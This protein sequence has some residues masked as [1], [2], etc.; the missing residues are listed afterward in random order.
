[1]E[2]HTPVTF[3]NRQGSRLFGVLDLPAQ[4]S[5]GQTSDL[6][7]IL[8]SPG[9]KMR[10]GPERLYR[11][12]TDLF[13]GMGVPSLRFD[14]W[15]LGDSE[16]TLK[17][18]FLKDVYNHIEVGR[19]VDDA[20]DAMDWMQRECGT[21]R[22]ILSGL[23]G[24][25]I[26]G[27][28]AGSRDRRVAGLLALGITPT[29]ASRAAD[30]SLYMTAGELAQMRRS[31]VSKLASPTAWLRLLTLQ[32]DYKVIWRSVIHPFKTARAGQ[33]EASPPPET[34]NASPL[35]PPAFFNMLES[36]RPMLLI[37]GGSDRLHWEFEEKFVARHGEK[38]AALPQVY[39]VHVIPRANHV[40]SFQEWQQEMVD[41]SRRWL[42]ANFARDVK[43][44][45][46]ST[47]EPAHAR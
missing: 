36:R 2:H 8:L 47:P 39:D 13:V 44:S 40:L 31:Y 43:V 4:A 37:F 14:F 22:F 23:C 1:M 26:T 42:I 38:L 12:V 20:I 45:A 41:V 3:P 30:P 18:E 19:F 35:F 28:L 24:G 46:S 9:V 21:R 7:L 17:E 10:V 15:G 29:L 6:G 16:G 34:D 11:R 5:A 25:A 32:S 33:Q 27:L